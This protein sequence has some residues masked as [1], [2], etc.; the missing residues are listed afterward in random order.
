[1]L[2]SHG[3][4]PLESADKQD[5]S[6]SNGNQAQTGAG[7]ITKLLGHMG[8]IPVYPAL[9]LVHPHYPSKVHVVA[10]TQ[11]QR[12]RLAIWCCHFLVLSSHH[13]AT[14]VRRG[15]LSVGLCGRPDFGWLH[16]IGVQK[17]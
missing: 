9:P 8:S 1:M 15:K 11:R 17:T 13:T 16:Q 6:C 5:R 12:P 2:V 3:L 14:D 7:D 4:R 10:G